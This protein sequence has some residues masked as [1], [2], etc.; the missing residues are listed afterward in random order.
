MRSDGSN[1]EELENLAQSELASL[2]LGNPDS[3]E[4]YLAEVGF[5]TGDTQQLLEGLYACV[6]LLCTGQSCLTSMFRDPPRLAK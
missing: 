5:W 1:E 4:G 2:S 3:R 6:V